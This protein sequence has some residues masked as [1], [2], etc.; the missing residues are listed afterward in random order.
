MFGTFEWYS[1]KLNIW[2]KAYGLSRILTIL[3]DTVYL[4]KIQN[5]LIVAKKNVFDGSASLF[6][7]YRKSNS[8]QTKTITSP[9]ISFCRFKT[10]MSYRHFFCYLNVRPKHRKTVLI[11]CYT[12]IFATSIVGWFTG[13]STQRQ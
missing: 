7:C 11:R 3:Y 5:S 13:E 4:S 9:V 12:M 10:A 1:S 6:F 2:N 8:R